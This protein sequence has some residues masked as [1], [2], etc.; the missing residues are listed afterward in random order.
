MRISRR[1]RRRRDRAAAEDRNLEGNTNVFR[2]SGQ[3]Y[4]FRKEENSTNI[5]NNYGASSNGSCE[6]GDAN[7]HDHNNNNDD[8]NAYQ[9]FTVPPSLY[10]ANHHSSASLNPDDPNTAA[11]TADPDLITA[12]H[13]SSIERHIH[14]ELDHRIAD[15]EAMLGLDEDTLNDDN[16]DDGEK[17]ITH[18]TVNDRKGVFVGTAFGGDVMMDSAQDIE[19]HSTATAACAAGDHYTD[20]ALKERENKVKE[21]TES[22]GIVISIH[23]TPTTAGVHVDT[24]RDQGHFLSPGSRRNTSNINDISF[25]QRTALEDESNDS[26]C[27]I[28][29]D[30]FVRYGFA[31]FEPL[32]DFTSDVLVSNLTWQLPCGHLYHYGCILKYSVEYN[33]D[34]CPCCRAKFKVF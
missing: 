30:E 1:E 33:K 31:E 9:N 27:C 2:L 16:D 17:D 19:L 29:L 5:K 12:T 32:T 11:S 15:V 8:N 10:T 6:S 28:C 21:Q 23:E 34:E 22:H 20:G 13:A 25:E 3:V 24:G 4:S 14:R 18:D 7:N 26:I